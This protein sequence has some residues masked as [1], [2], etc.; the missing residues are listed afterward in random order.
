MRAPPRGHRTP[1]EK[2]LWEQVCHFLRHD[3]AFVEESVGLRCALDEEDLELLW[4]ALH[5]L[6]AADVPMS[7]FPLACISEELYVENPRKP[8]SFL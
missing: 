5:C 1:E 4:T 2:A 7:G 6:V 3:R 8:Y